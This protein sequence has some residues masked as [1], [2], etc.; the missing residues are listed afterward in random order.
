MKTSALLPLFFLA[1]VACNDPNKDKPKATTDEAKPAAMA[2]QGASYAFDGSN[3]TVGFVGAKITGTHEG[4]FKKLQGKVVIPG[5]DLTKGSV[6]VDIDTTSVVTDQEKLT[7]HLKSPDFFDTEKFPKATFVSTAVKAGGEGGAT[8][9]VTGNLTM[10]GVTK[11]ITFPAKARLDGG[12]FSLDAEFKINRK[13]FNIT[14]AGK[15]DDLIKDDVL[16]KLSIKASKG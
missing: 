14:Y 8:H 9:T 13:E 16:M 3:S 5:D 12:A 15:A 1:V 4:S 10:R 11:S 2:V 6:S 7:T